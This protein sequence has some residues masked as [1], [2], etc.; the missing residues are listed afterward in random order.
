MLYRCRVC[1]FIPLQPFSYLSIW[2]DVAKR[3]VQTLREGLEYCYKLFDFL[4]VFIGE[5]DF[6]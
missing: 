4:K 2:T 1:N 3:E 6:N 5:Y